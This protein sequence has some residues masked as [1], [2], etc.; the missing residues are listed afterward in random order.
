MKAHSA[1]VLAI[2]A[3]CH[4]VNAA[5][6]R[7]IGDD[8]QKPWAD[9]P[10]WQRESAANGV[11]FHLEN[12]D[13]GD[14]ASH[15]NW[16]AE[17]VAAGWVVGGGKDEKKKT[18]PCLVPFD[19]LPPG[20]QLKDTLFR[21]VVHAAAPGFADLT[22][23]YADRGIE[24][25]NVQALLRTKTEDLAKVQGKLDR[26]QRKVKSAAKP[27]ARESA[28]KARAIGAPAEPMIRQ[29]F[30]DIMQSA[31]DKPL[32]LVFSDGKREILE[33][34]PLEVWPAG[35]RRAGARLALIAAP[36]VRGTVNPSLRV[37]GVG[38]LADGEQ[39]AWCEFPDPV[40]VPL[41]GEVKFDRMIAF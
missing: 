14:A 1:S 36:H 10:E 25:D 31:R 41:G 21:A 39:I 18:H 7:S 22:Q 29:A 27:V 6:C 38:L 40:E 3:I 8:S 28:G 15:E 32:E 37:R 20:Q 12:P 30:D 23:A 2:A 34:D 11:A 4:G 5:Y 24:L 26:A 9:A 13:A 17:K 33:I 35:F 19:Q 16:M